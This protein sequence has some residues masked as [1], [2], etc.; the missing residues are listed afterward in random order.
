MQTK[1]KHDK[2][3]CRDRAQKNKESARNTLSQMLS[4]RPSKKVYLASFGL[5]LRIQTKVIFQAT[6]Q[7]WLITLFS[8]H[9]RSKLSI[10]RILKTN[11]FSKKTWLWKIWIRNSSKIKIKC[12]PKIIQI[13]KLMRCSLLATNM[14][15][16]A[17]KYSLTWSTRT[18]LQTN[19]QPG[20]S[21]QLNLAERK[22][23]RQYLSVRILIS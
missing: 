22:H 23:R 17:D 1:K 15:W 8:I 14:Q 13:K 20:D 10:W 2:T 11:W 21:L 6:R 7:T 19:T 5:F 12:K 16:K 9:C 18:F 3:K 4:S